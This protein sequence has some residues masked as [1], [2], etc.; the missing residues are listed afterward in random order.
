MI[1][2]KYSMI[3]KLMQYSMKKL[4]S[5]FPQLKSEFFKILKERI[6]ANNFT[7]ELFEK[8]VNRVIDTCTYPTIADVIGYKK[9][10]TNFNYPKLN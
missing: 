6:E 3:L 1:S 5:A 7:D 8:A 9:D 4:E 10:E 2:A